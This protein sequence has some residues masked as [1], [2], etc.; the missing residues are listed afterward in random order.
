[1]LAVVAEC[2]CNFNLTFYLCNIL[3]VWKLTKIN[4]FKIELKDKVYSW[5]NVCTLSNWCHTTR[6]SLPFTE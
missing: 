4:E 2:H 1:M 5:E 6:K 3:I